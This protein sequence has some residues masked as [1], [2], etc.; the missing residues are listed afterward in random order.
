MW[1]ME[2]A[3]EKQMQN[4]GCTRQDGGSISIPRHLYTIVSPLS[5]QQTGSPTVTQ[6]VEK[7][8]MRKQE[9]LF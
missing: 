4:R 6:T 2:Q 5:P 3:A 8:I 9:A 1:L 7:H